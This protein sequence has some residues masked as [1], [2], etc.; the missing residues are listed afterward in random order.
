MPWAPTRGSTRRRSWH[1]PPERNLLAQLKL[2]PT[3]AGY[4]AS[5]SVTRDPAASVPEGPS[6]VSSARTRPRQFSVVVCLAVA[7]GIRAPRASRLAIP[8]RPDPDGM[9]PGGLRA[10]EFDRIVAAVRSFALT[11]TGA[12][13]LDALTPATEPAAVRDTDAIGPI[14]SPASGTRGDV[15][16]Q[17]ARCMVQS[18]LP[19]GLSAS[20]RS[21]RDNQEGF[22][23][24]YGDG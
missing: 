21:R 24:G 12:A 7:S 1:V 14:I 4:W 17:V 2:R 6:C 10:L 15:S 8:P 18:F 3:T 19:A 22:H 5:T 9:R 16:A 13:R 20:R 23:H 11:P